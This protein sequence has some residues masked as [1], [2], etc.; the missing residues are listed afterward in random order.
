MKIGT[1]FVLV[2]ALGLIFFGGF[3]NI[4]SKTLLHFQSQSPGEKVGRWT[5]VHGRI[6]TQN[7][8][9]VAWKP[10]HS[11]DP[12]YLGDRIRMHWDGDGALALN[13]GTLLQMRPSSEVQILSDDQGVFVS[14]SKGLIGINP[15]QKG[16]LRI[17]DGEKVVDFY[18]AELDGQNR[19]DTDSQSELTEKI[20]PPASAGKTPAPPSQTD[21]TTNKKSP[22]P[23]PQNGVVLL[24]R[25]QAQVEIRP[26]EKCQTACQLLIHSRKRGKVANQAFRPGESPQFIYRIS[27]KGLADTVTWTLTV[28]EE[29]LQGLFLIEPF[30]PEIFKKNIQAQRPIEILN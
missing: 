6:R 20:P 27:E 4:S 30:T 28:G 25:G 12:V 7:R 9:S 22:F 15:M 29:K 26:L 5:Q 17:Y 13:S 18:S 24:H 23:L 21:F 8:G 11:D 19:G 10:V 14:L 1:V 3:K 2:I 16:K